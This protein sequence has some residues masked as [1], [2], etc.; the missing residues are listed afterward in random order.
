MSCFAVLVLQFDSAAMNQE[1]K[2]RT[3]AATSRIDASVQKEG[4]V[5]VPAKEYA[6]SPSNDSRQFSGRQAGEQGTRRSAHNYSTRAVESRISMYSSDNRLI[7]LSCILLLWYR[8]SSLR[9]WVFLVVCVKGARGE[10]P[11][12]GREKWMCDRVGSKRPKR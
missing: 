10:K 9:P 3:A 12:G 8:L 7:V 4:N 6:N 11:A 2:E 5:A 1:T